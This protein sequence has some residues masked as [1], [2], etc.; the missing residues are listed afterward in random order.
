MN[1]ALWALAFL[2]GAPCAGFF[3]T[4]LTLPRSTR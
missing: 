4:F 2:I 1:D 3:L